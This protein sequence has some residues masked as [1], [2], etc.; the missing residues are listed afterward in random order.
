MKLK[1][2]CRVTE[3]GGSS[4]REEPRRVSN[5]KR[6]GRSYFP[7]LSVPSD[8]RSIFAVM[9]AHSSLHTSQLFPLAAYWSVVY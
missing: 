9:K 4:S 6:D 7:C 5:L 2:Q 3:P 1:V 8:I